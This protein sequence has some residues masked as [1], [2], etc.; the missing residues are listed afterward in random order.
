MKLQKYL[1][2]NSANLEGFELETKS[3][4]GKIAEMKAAGLQK[5]KLPKTKDL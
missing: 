1:I 2:D 5:H 3:A 4:D